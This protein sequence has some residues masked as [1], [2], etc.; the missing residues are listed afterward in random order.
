M[1]KELSE[2]TLEEL[3]ELFPIKLEEHNNDYINWYE[4]EKQNLLECIDKKDIK[5]INH[6]GS[7]AVKGLISKPTVDILFEI[8]INTNTDKLKDQLI[9]NGWILMSSGKE[10]N[11]NMSFN[12]GYTKKGYAEKVYHLHV[13]H[14]DDWNELYFRDYLRDHKEV[15]SEYEKL[16][17]SLLEKYRN[18]RDEYTH[19]KADFV[20]KYSEKAK[21][22]YKNKY[23]PLL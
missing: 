1:C 2:L 8:D 10:P 5:R 15:A 19:A 3:Y 18:D 23:K 14:Y 6:I 11:F 22:E 21:T 16:K 12:K 9:N 17:L 20:L 4:T 13:R 7:S